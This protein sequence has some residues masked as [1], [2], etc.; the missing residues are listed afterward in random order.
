MLSDL[1]VP[2]VEQVLAIED[3][4]HVV[5]FDGVC[6]FC[7]KSVQFIADRD[8]RNVFR[9]ASLQSEATE[10]LRTKY[11]IP[12]N[13]DTVCLIHN[14][15]LYTH[16][17]AVLR[18][19]LH[20]GALWPLLAVFL[21]I[22]R[23]LRDA[24]YGVIARSRYRFWGTKEI[25]RLPTPEDADRFLAEPTPE[26]VSEHVKN[27]IMTKM[28]HREASWLRKILPQSTRNEIAEYRSGKKIAYPLAPALYVIDVIRAVLFQFQKWRVGQ[29]ASGVAFF[30]IIG[31]VPT[32]MMLVVATELVGLTDVIGEFVIDAIITNYIPLERAK[33]LETINEWVSNARTTV[34]G[35]LGLLFM[36]MAAMNVFGGVYSLVN[37]LWQVP[38]RGRLAHKIGAAFLAL[39]L[40]PSALGASTW[41]T[42][43]VGGIQ[44]VGA[45]ASR[46]ISFALIFAIAYVGLRITARVKVERK[47]A[48]IAAAFGAFAFEI[49]KTIFAFY[50]HEL[51]EG[52]WFVIYGAIFLFPVFMLWNFVAAMIVA[53]TASLGWVIQNPSEAFYDAGISCP[54]TA[55]LERGAAP[56][57]EL[58]CLEDEFFGATDLADE[59]CEMPETPRPAATDAT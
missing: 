47:S 54:H 12:T 14:G 2:T 17:S 38:V 35:G 34:A 8:H 40:V 46:L 58:P 37:D 7:D 52:S 9:F 55:D 11:A 23:F 29:R 26:Q 45:L 24:W 36:G 21:V 13:I 19:A 51:V 43:Q 31:F 57:P 41:L 3:R 28:R 25:C 48:A 6:N 1:D 27:S 44:Y 49:A 59:D 33:A 22:P 15:R 42:A 53:G 16:S 5:L 50:I 30:I 20:L 39:L 10:L 32:V 56:A 18:I 4:H